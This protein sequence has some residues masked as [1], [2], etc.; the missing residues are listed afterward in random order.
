MRTIAGEDLFRFKLGGDIQICPNKKLAVYVENQADRKTNSY[1]TRIIKIWPGEK[2]EPFTHGPHDQSPQFSPDGQWLAFI[3]K[4]S[5]Q[6][7]IWVMSTAGGE[8]QQVSHIDGGIESFIWAPDSRTFYAT[9]L[10][11]DAGIVDENATDNDDDYV[12][13]NKDVKV[14]TE[15]SHKMD[16][17]GFYGP[18]RPHIIRLTRDGGEPV[19]LTFGPYRHSQLAISQDGRQLFFSS[20]YGEDY[21]RE[22]F[23]HHIYVL[24][25]SDTQSSKPGQP[26][27]ISPPGLSA[28]SPAMHPDGEHLFFI[29]TRTEDLGY[30]NPSLYVLPLSHPDQIRMIAP[31]WDRPFADESL[32]DML[33]PASNPLR[34]DADGSHIFSLTSYN[35][36]VQLA[37]IDWQHDQVELLT[38]GDHVYYSYDISSDA[39]LAILAKSTPTNPSQIEW[40][41]SSA[42]SYDTQLLTNPNQELLASLKLSTPARF[43]Y[44]AE[45]GPEIDGWVLPP[46]DREEGKKYP[47][48]LEIHGG[49]MMMYADSFFLEFQWLAAHGYGVI[50][51]NPR[52]SQGYGR[53][54]CLAIQHEWGNL[55]YQDIMAGLDTALAENPWIDKD[56]LAVAGGS[57][58]GYMT[59]WIIGHSQRFKAAITMRSVVDWKAMVGTG[60]GGWHWMRRAHNQKPWQSDDDWYRQQSPITYVEN[61][62]TPLLIEHQE[63]D[64]R[65][66]IEQGE[67]LYTAVKYLNKAP[68]KFIRY[69]EEFHGMSRNGKPWH[70]IFR[71]NSFTDWLA[72]YV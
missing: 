2:P 5:G 64:L 65:C 45:N 62:T 71:L 54:F 28:S 20:R 15:L 22:S 41:E 56:R 68:V 19:Q 4:R 25:V 33:G 52:G 6:K 17:I 60:D 1:H 40:L 9:A 31:W 26:Q 57:Y 3:S 55:D 37:R 53:E 18:R 48:V 49:P 14:I 66:P 69:P 32:S 24:D 16:G 36:T 51:T 63:G 47:A 34:F 11:T 23:E 35:G 7:Q 46:V 13:F 27:R 30:D 67:I 42:S 29:G 12:K 21:D 38:K 72:Q 43:H 59:N 10:L 39:Q 44:H 70:R 8:A 58:G 61:I 50:Y